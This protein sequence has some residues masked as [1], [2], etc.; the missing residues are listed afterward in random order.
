MTA[1]LNK[2]IERLPLTITQKNNL[3][4]EISKAFR[5]NSPELESVQSFFTVSKSYLGQLA[6]K[7]E[8]IPFIA[9]QSVSNIQKELISNFLELAEI[10]INQTT[11][12][13]PGFANAI[14]IG[15]QFKIQ[16]V[17]P[18]EIMRTLSQIR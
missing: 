11:V 2:F 8:L 13:R 1:E 4:Y 12:E 10:Q 16:K 15:A 9:Q 6:F 5:K 7:N 17:D 18:E 3:E 14:H